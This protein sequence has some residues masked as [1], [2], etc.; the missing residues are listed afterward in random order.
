[1]VRGLRIDSQVDSQA[2]G[3]GAIPVDTSGIASLLTRLYG[4]PRTLADSIP[5][6]WEQGVVGSN[7]AVPTNGGLVEFGGFSSRNWP[8]FCRSRS[9]G[10][11]PSRWL[12][13]EGPSRF[14]V[15]AK[16][17][18]LGWCFHSECFGPYVLC[19]W[20]GCWRQVALVPM[21]NKDLRDLQAPT[22]SKALRDLQAPTV[23]KALRDLQ[24]PTVSKDLRV[25]RGLRDR[26]ARRM[27]RHARMRPVLLGP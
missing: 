11:N 10:L 4:H 7:P 26:V 12:P 5:R 2:G 25:R 8:G 23:S 21:V 1:M 3:H 22:V 16:R 27:V 15:V 19:S 20:L 17:T 14:V 24:A 13:G 18:V 6:L 9:E